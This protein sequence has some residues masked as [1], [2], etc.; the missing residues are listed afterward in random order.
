MTNLKKIASILRKDEIDYAELFQAIQNFKK[1]VLELSGID[2]QHEDS[3]KDMYFKNGKAIGATWAA[4]CLDDFVRTKIF[5]KGLCNAIDALLEKKRGPLHILYAGCGPFATLILPALSIYSKNEIQ[6]TLLE[7]NT[8]SLESAKRV[9]GKLGYDDYILSYQNEDATK[10]TV[11]NIIPIDIVL[12]ETM[13]CGL[14]KEQQVPIV[15]NI[16]KQVEKETVLIPEMIA[17]DLCLMNFQKFTSRVNKT[18][19]SDYCF[20]LDRLIEIS[21][22]KINDYASKLERSGTTLLFPEKLITINAKQTE[23]FKDLIL[24][25]RIT[26]FGKEKILVNESGLTL[27]IKLKKFSSLSEKTT[28]KTRY[29][30]DEKPRFEYEWI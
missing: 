12:S 1:I 30:I 14:V 8:I 27:P 11:D 29:V 4:L 7:I 25:T 23:S 24:I 26:V 9:I 17:V 28:L 22:E 3:K 5:I 10:Y 2:M 18:P 21:A 15:M 16:M 19:E 20:V 6:C 13:Q